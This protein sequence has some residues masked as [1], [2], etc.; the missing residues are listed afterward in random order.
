MILNV[1]INLVCKSMMKIL[2]TIYN[3][4]KWWNTVWL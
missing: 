4:E 2:C 3:E 1:I